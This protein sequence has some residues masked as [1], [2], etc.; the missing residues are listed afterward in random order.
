MSPNILEQLLI[1]T[2]NH[3]LAQAPWARQK[4]MQLAGQPIRVV[5][6]PLDVTLVF[7]EDGWI[8]VSDVTPVASM[9]LTPWSMLRLAVNEVGATR[10]IDLQGDAWLAARFGMILRSLTWDAEADLARLLGDVVA[11]A[12]LRVVR[13]WVRWQ[14]AGLFEQA[15]AWMEYA[16]E[17]ANVLIRGEQLSGFI[18]DVDDLRNDTARL[19][20][21][22]K[23][24]TQRLSSAH[25]G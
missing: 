1:T 18:A 10:T 2:L 17:E 11:Q 6:Y 8:S 22:I 20:K 21:R 3:L 9:A 19:E 12:V 23:L 7:D 14:S 25:T 24:L 16:S 4:A 13:E 5:A 15:R